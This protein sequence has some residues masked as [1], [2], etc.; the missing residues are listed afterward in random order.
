[1]EDGR[2]TKRYPRDF[3]EETCM[4]VQ[5]YPLYRRRAPSGTAVKNGHV[6]DARDVVPYSPVLSRKL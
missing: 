2:C 1:M 5:G 4:N 3:Q 6:I